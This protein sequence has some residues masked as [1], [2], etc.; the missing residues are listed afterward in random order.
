GDRV[1]PGEE[2]LA[3]PAVAVDIRERPG[4]DLAAEVLGVAGLTDPV[5]EVAVDAVHVG[6]V[7]LRER[8]TVAV[9]GAIDDVRDRA[10]RIEAERRCERQGLD[11]CNGH[12]H[13]VCPFPFPLSAGS[14]IPSAST[15]RQPPRGTKHG[16]ANGWAVPHSV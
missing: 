2:R 1:Q 4:E 14:T 8:G 7:E 3:L 10:E 6:V 9:T 11:A 13:V 12:A 5:Q 15:Y 16:S